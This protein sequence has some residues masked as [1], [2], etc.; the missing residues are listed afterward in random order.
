MRYILLLGGNLGNVEKTMREAV[1]HIAQ[2]GDVPL[3]SS[4]YES[5]PWGFDAK[6][7]F[8]NMAIEL[9][10]D[11]EPI[12]LLD[13]LQRIERQMGRTHKTVNRQY[14]SRYIDIDILLCEDRIVD[15][16]RLTIPHKLMHEREF[17]LVPVAE[18]WSDWQ[19][20]ILHKSVGELLELLIG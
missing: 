1:K 18:L 20:P 5:E 9:D 13:E 12:A 7:R 17:A 16:E 11:L 2:L 15:T 6:E 3:L 4:V 8:K 19:H 10:T 14:Q